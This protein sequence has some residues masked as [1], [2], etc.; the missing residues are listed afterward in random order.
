M[1]VEGDD[2]SKYLEEAEEEN[3]SLVFCNILDWTSS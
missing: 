3:T 2:I 1:R